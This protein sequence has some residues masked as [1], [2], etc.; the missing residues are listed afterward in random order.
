MIVNSY[1]K[2]ARS[3]IKR[4]DRGVVKKRA[5]L[6]VTISI[7]IYQ[8]DMKELVRFIPVLGRRRKGSL[9]KCKICASKPFDFDSR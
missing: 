6:I 7:N 4:L 5:L 1:E 2:S 3:L 8:A 9:I